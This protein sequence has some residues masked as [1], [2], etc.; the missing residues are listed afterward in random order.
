M[1]GPI[2][3]TI[4]SH[5][6]DLAVFGVAVGLYG[7]AG[8]ANPFARELFSVGGLALVAAVKVGGALVAALI[9]ARRRQWLWLAAGSGLLGAVTTLVALA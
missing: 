5:L 1:T 9:V 7:I 3:A 8:E 6:A 4:A 2:T